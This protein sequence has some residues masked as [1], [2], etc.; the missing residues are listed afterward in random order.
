MKVTAKLVGRTIPINVE[1]NTPEELIAYAARVSNPSNQSNHSTADRLLR[2]CMEHKHWSVFEMANAIV[3]VEAPRDITRQLLRHRSFSFQEFSQRYSDEIEFTD[4]SF[5]RQ[6]NKN[7]QNSVDDLP[8]SVLAYAFD[9]MNLI[10][11]MCQ[12][13]YGKLRDADVA[14]EP[15]E[16]HR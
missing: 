4:R 6:D 5:R 12:G 3:E 8:K 14:K 7:R 2:Y 11:D 9:T 10:T 15:P 13:A 1:A 16:Q